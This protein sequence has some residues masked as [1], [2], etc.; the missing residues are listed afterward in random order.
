M[1]KLTAPDATAGSF[2]GRVGLSEGWLIAGYL[3]PAVGNNSGA[4]YVFPVACLPTNL[5]DFADF[6]ICLTGDGGGVRFG[7]GIFDFDDDADI[8]LEDYA[9]LLPSFV[10]P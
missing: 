8:D 3:N 4:T 5:T 1:A 2:F 9:C 6:Q 7:C 10:G